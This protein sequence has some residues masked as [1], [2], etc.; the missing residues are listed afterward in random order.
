MWMFMSACQGRIDEEMR[1]PAS[2]GF[3][4]TLGVA[5][6]LVLGGAEL[7]ARAAT[8]P[9]TIMPDGSVRYDYGRRPTPVLVCRPHYVCDIT[10]DTGE[11]VLNMAIGDSTRW[12]IAGGQSGPGGNTPHVFVKPTQPDLDT[13]LVITTTKRVYDVALRSANDA[14]YPR[15]R[16]F[17]ADD[18]AASKA[19]IAEHERSAIEG[20]LAGTPLVGADQ[21]DAKYKIGGEASLAPDKVFNDGVRTFIE[22]KA[23]PAEL[24]AVVTITKEGTA[25]PTNFRVVANAYIVEGVNPNYDLVLSAVNERHGRP[26]RRA[27]IRHL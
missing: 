21:A 13:N 26:E 3:L 27:S 19:A 6:A 9:S 17:Y 11:S 23:L 4:S 8:S 15:L 14:K 12:V 20:V 10:L 2:I 24:P 18:D 1:R 25:Q 5:F 22:W 7:P 16:F